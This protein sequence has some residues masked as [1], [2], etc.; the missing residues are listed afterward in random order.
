VIL[1]PLYRN[2]REKLKKKQ[3]EEDTHVLA[4]SSHWIQAGSHPESWVCWSWMS[5]YCW[6]FAEPHPETTPSSSG[7]DY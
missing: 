1:F 4:G 5:H 7:L 2:C 6:F 3:K